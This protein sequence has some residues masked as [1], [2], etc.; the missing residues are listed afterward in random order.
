MIFRLNFFYCY[1]YYYCDRKKWNKI[2]IENGK[3]FFDYIIWEPVKIKI[4]IRLKYD[5]FVLQKNIDH[6]NEHT[7]KGCF[8]VI[9]SILV[10]FVLIDVIVC[11]RKKLFPLIFFWKQYASILGKK[12]R[13]QKHIEFQRMQWIVKVL[14]STKK[15]LRKRKIFL[16]VFLVSISFFSRWFCLSWHNIF[17]SILGFLYQDSHFILIFH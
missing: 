12:K 13:N 3:N 6:K 9:K 2:E 15:K 14:F 17:F 11:E 4:L 7:C 16:C 10:W 8:Y 5:F 1:F